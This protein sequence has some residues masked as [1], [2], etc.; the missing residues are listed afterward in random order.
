MDHLVEY[1]NVEIEPGAEE[2]QSLRQK[3][4]RIKKPMLFPA[5]KKLVQSVN[6]QHN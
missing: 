1:C 3:Q 6:L 2:T 5:R 4:T